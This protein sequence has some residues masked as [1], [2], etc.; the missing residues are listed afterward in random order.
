[1][2]AIDLDYK[3]IYGKLAYAVWLI[4]PIIPTGETMQ[5]KSSPIL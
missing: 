5:W 4:T 2:I 3:N 1:L